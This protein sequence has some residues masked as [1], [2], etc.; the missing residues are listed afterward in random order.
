MNSRLV[1]RVTTLNT[2]PINESGEYV[3]YWMISNRRYH[4]NAALEYAAHMA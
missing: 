2:S 1:D 3:L 4:S